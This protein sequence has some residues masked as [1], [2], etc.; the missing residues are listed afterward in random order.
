MEMAKI[1]S[2]GENQRKMAATSWRGN[3]EANGSMASSEK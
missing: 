1:G 2:G 3:R